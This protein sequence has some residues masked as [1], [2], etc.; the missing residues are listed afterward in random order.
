MLPPTPSRPT[1]HIVDPPQPAAPTV[2]PD[3]PEQRLFRVLNRSITEYAA[4]DPAPTF[5]RRR[6]IQDEAIHALTHYFGEK[7]A[8]IAEARKGTWK[9]NGK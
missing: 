3:T 9:G 2:A 7:L 6:Q 1:L 5:R 4:D 8:A